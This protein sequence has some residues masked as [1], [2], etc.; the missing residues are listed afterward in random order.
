MENQKYQKKFVIPD[1]VFNNK[2]LTNDIF[3]DQKDI[4][5]EKTPESLTYLPQH[6]GLKETRTE[7]NLVYFE[8]LH[9]R[10]P[11]MIDDILIGTKETVLSSINNAIFQIS[12][13]DEIDTECKLAMELPIF[14]DKSLISRFENIR[15][16]VNDFFT[17]AIEKRTNKQDFI[18]PAEK[19]KENYVESQVRTNPLIEEALSQ[20]LNSSTITNLEEWIMTLKNNH[21]TIINPITNEERTF[22]I[23]NKKKFHSGGSAIIL[24]KNK[25]RL[26]LIGGFYNLG[27]SL[28]PSNG[29]ISK[30][31]R[32]P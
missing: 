19:V 30:Y 11:K 25:K 8:R 22:E 18:K 6:E 29:K 15:A 12:N 31:P 28:N 9:S 16:S 17:S 4:R 5:I 7:T 14:Y 2:L 27:I 1:K 26:H 10:I 32:Y 13:L 24:S 21:M 23:S 3:R 20:N